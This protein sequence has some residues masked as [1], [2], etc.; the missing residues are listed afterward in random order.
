M[1]LDGLRKTVSFYVYLRKIET[2]FSTFWV[3]LSCTYPVRI[4]QLTFFLFIQSKQAKMRQTCKWLTVLAIAGLNLVLSLR[5]PLFFRR[6]LFTLYRD[7]APPFTCDVYYY[8]PCIFWPSR[9]DN[10]NV[11]TIQRLIILNMYKPVID[12]TTAILRPC[13]K[14]KFS[15]Y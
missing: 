8:K 14:K 5:L 1:T 13:S 2:P 7:I 3:T 15:V 12:I 4:G 9:L 6:K 10:A 11:V